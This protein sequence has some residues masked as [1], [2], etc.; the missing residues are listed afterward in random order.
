MRQ[1][2]C[3]K[4]CLVHNCTDDPTPKA[5]R[6]A[7]SAPD[8][9]KL[10]TLQEKLQNGSFVQLKDVESAI[11]HDLSVTHGELQQMRHGIGSALYQT[12]QKAR[13]VF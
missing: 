10:P 3:T 12:I 1:Y 13:K 5:K 11:V 8:L 7:L 2:E 6:F 9:A 4:A